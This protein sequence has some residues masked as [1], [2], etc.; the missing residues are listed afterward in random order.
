MQIHSKNK[1]IN[2]FLS[3]VANKLHNLSKEPNE[4]KQTAENLIVETIKT[5]C[6][7]KTDQIDHLNDIGMLL[8][9]ETNLEHLLGEI[10][11]K[12]KLFTNS[13]GGTLYIMSENEELLVFKIVETD[14]LGIHMG[15]HGE[16]IP[17]PAVPLY[18]EDGS[19]NHEMVAA[20]CALTAKVLNFQDVYDAE[21]FNF[22]GTRKFD[23][24]TGFRSKSMLVIPMINSRK[25]VIGVVQLLNARDCEN[26]VISFTNEDERLLLSLASQAAVAITNAKMIKDL[27]ELL[28]SFIKSIAFAVDQKS[29]HTGGH[30]NKVASISLKIAKALNKATT[31]KYADVHYTKQEIDEIRISALMHDVGKITTPSHVMDKATKLETIYDMI[32]VIRVKFIVYKQELTIEM[33]NKKIQLIGSGAS[34]SEIQLLEDKLNEEIDVLEDELVFLII[35]NV[36]VEFMTDEHIQ[37]VKKIAQRRVKMSGVEQNLLSDFEVNN[38]CIRKGTLTEEELVI[39]R[40]HARVS[41]EM[42]DALPFPKHLKRVPSIAGGHHEKLNG[43]GYPKGL[44]ADELSLES[45]ILALADIFEALSASDRPYKGAK[46]MSEIIKI[47]NFMVKDG[48]LDA[49][50]VQFFYDQNIHLR[51]AKQCF[52]PEQIDI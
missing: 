33:L 45:R 22:S 15:V 16:E 1:E 27:K 4:N 48:E 49:D 23:E 38:L 9:I 50:L 47:I 32:D 44:K 14:S 8:S 26:N 6:E 46:T 5:F 37:R 52:K 17:W 31:G 18:L 19:Q 3:H 21:G 34:L 40:D 20:H 42:L 25:E 36:G 2:R 41:N 43:K 39:M 35:S 24:S 7:K 13:D 30:V 11:S 12:S 29:P 51:F 28:E 10:I